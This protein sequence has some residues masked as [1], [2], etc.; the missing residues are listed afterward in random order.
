MNFSGTRLVVVGAG[1]RFPYE[2][3]KERGDQGSEVRGKGGMALIR[4]VLGGAGWS[5]QGGKSGKAVE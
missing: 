4:Y 5:S 1:V 2:A 3:N